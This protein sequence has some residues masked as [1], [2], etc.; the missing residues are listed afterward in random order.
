MLVT[1]NSW[2]DTNVFSIYHCTGFTL[3]NRTSKDQSISAIIIM[4]I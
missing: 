3:A 2:D 4:G 1:K